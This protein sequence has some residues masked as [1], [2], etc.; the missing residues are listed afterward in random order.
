MVTNQN[1]VFYTNKGEHDDPHELH[2]QQNLE[3]STDT[4]HSLYS[5]T[6]QFPPNMNSIDEL[7]YIYQHFKDNEKTHE[8][9]P[10]TTNHE[11]YDTLHPY[12]N[13][14]IEYGLFEDVVKSYY[15]DRQIKDDFNCD[16]ECYVTPSQTQPSQQFT[17]FTHAYDYIKQ[18]IN[19]LADTTQ[20]NTLHTIK[21]DASLFTSDTN[22][23]C[24]YNITE[25][26]QNSHNILDRTVQS[27]SSI[28]IHS[29]S[30]HKYRDVF[31]DSHI[32][33]HDFD[34]GDAFTFKNKYTALLQQELQ[35]P[36]WCLYVPITTKTYQISTEMDIESMPHA[37]YLQGMKSQLQKLIMY[38]IRPLSM[39]IKVCFRYN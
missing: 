9:D 30:K 8:I 37:I 18:H 38:H 20:Q 16:K 25:P 36:Y 5:H 21:E 39:M 7:G 35:N 2:E 10:D 14:N 33:Y 12:I 19:N 24:E 11:F 28:G 27:K 15:L 6:S 13:N 31:G 22:T 4:Y 17:S 3:G 34:N 32:Q 26:I 29:Q 23:P 1:K